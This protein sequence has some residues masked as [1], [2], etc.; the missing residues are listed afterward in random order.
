M[1]KIM[2]SL[3]AAALATPAVAAPP[4]HAAPHSAASAEQARIPFPGMRIRNFHAEGR[5]VVYLEDQSRNWYRA[6]VV[7]TCTDL[8]FA[9]AIGIDTRGS[10]SFDRFSAIVVGNDRC[11]LTSLTRSEKP[12]R[13]KVKKRGA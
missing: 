10:S 1:N 3:V 12:V 6:E 4:H 9:Q 7:G 5:D 11:Q 2:L 8:P 13:K